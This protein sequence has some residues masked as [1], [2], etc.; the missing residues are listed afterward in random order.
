MVCDFCGSW[1]LPVENGVRTI[2]CSLINF[3]LL[4]LQITFKPK[5][6]AHP[7]S[8]QP[9]M[10]L[11]STPS[12]PNFISLHPL[13]HLL[14]CIW[15]SAAPGHDEPPH[16]PVSNFKGFIECQKDF[17]TFFF[18]WMYLCLSWSPVVTF[19]KGSVWCRSSRPKEQLYRGVPW[20]FM[21]YFKSLPVV[22]VQS[23]QRMKPLYTKICIS[24]L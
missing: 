5:L 6:T 11:P 3:C 9:F 21:C 18:S 24:L 10:P 16:I 8:S 22:L 15:L 14:P 12:S 1:K 23:T 17:G 2:S 20:S 19:S 7:S 13:S 4:K